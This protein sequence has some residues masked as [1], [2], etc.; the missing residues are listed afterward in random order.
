[1]LGLRL[2]TSGESLDRRRALWFVS[3]QRVNDCRGV[4]GKGHR[5]CSHLVNHRTKR[6][7]IRPCIQPLTAGL[8]R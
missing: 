7:Q 4:A 5:S 8:F 3:R 1:M 6:E 2:S